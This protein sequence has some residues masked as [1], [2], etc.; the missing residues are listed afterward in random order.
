LNKYFQESTSIIQTFIKNNENFFTGLNDIQNGVSIFVRNS[1]IQNEHFKAL[2][3][4]MLEMRQDFRQSQ[5]SN[6]ELNRELVEAIKGLTLKIS[7][8]E[9]ITTQETDNGKN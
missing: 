5:Q 9:I 8:L 6:Y 7:K 2:N 1:A 4:G 3:V